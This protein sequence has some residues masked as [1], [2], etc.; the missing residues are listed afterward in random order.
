MDKKQVD[1]LLYEMS[2]LYDNASSEMVDTLQKVRKE[3]KA[4]KENGM[5]GDMPHQDL[6]AEWGILKDGLV[7]V[8]TDL[9]GTQVEEIASL[10]EI[11]PALRAA[12][13]DALALLH[14]RRFHSARNAFKALTEKLDPNSPLAAEV[15]EKQEEAGRKLAA[16]V[17]PLI[18]KAQKYDRNKPGDLEQRRS[19]WEA[20]TEIDP[21]NQTARQALES[22]QQEGSRLRIQK[23]QEELLQAMQRAFDARNLPDANTQLGALEALAEANTFIDLQAELDD[24]VKTASEQRAKLREILGAASTLSVQGNTREGYKQ[25]REFL[26]AGV[27]VMVD[28]AGFLGPANAE[29]KTLELVKVTQSRF[30]ASLIDLTQQRRVLAEEQQRE[31]PALAKKTLEN[32][33]DL[34]DDD[35]LTDEDRQELEDTRQ[36]IE[37]ELTQVEERIRHYEQA[38]TLVLKANEAGVSFEEKL[39]LYREAKEAY[40]EYRNLDNYIEDTQD[41]LAAQ[42]AGRIKDKLTSIRLDLG[43][44]EF[45]KALDGVKVVRLQ[46]YEEVPQ[47]KPGSELQRVLDELQQLE[48]EIITADGQYHAMMKL[49]LEVDDLLEQYGEKQDAN[50]LAEVRQRLDSLPGSQAQHSQVR[51]R[52]LRLTNTQGDQENWRQGMEAYRIREWADAQT[53]LR[54]VADSPKAANRVEAERL[55]RRAQAALYVAEARQAELERN[56]RRAIDHYKEAYR[57]F[58]ENGS[59]DQT[60]LLHDDCRDKLDS[61]KPLE[62]N[63]QQ[64]RHVIAQAESLVREGLQSVQVRRSLLE[65]VEPVTQFKRAVEKLLEVRQQ[66]TTLTAELERTLREAREAW[67]KT[68]LEGMTQATRS[69]DVHILQRA[70]QRG[71]EL[72]AQNLLYEDNDKKL[73][74][75]L[76]EQLLDT[77]YANLQVEKVPDPARVE[78]NRRKR[79]EIANPKTDE[80]YAQFQI[81]MEQRVLLQL[82]EE[83]SKSNEAALQHLK[84]EMRRPELYQSERLFREFMH[85]CWET[86]NWQEARK[87]GEG[88]K[89]R[90][91]VVQAEQKSIVWVGLT[92]AAMLLAQ[93]SLP[94]FRAELNGLSSIGQKFPQMTFLIEDEEQWL[95]EWRLE[96]LLRE[97][98]VAGGSQDEQQLIKAA[99]LFAEAHELREEDV[100]VQT[101]LINLGQKLNSSLE[102]YAGQAKNLNIRK[103]LAESIRRA[104][105]LAF[106]LQSIQKVQGVLNLKPETV[107]AL[108][109]G[110]EHIQNK[111][112]PWKKTQ[113]Q[114]DRLEK[115]KTDYL[116]Y[117]EPL[118]PDGSG[119]WRVRD[120]V[121]QMTPLTQIA[122]GDRELIQLINTRR[123]QLTELD[124]KAE[125][126]NGQAHALAQAIQSEAFDEV[127]GAAN[128]LEI[129]WHRYQPDG[130]SGLDILIRHRYP[131]TEK[132]LRQLREHKEEA[133]TQKANLE[134]WQNWAERV[135]KTYAE[136]KAVGSR[137]DKDL[138]DLR[139]DAPLDEIKRSCDQVL[140]KTAEFEAALG[141]APHTNPMSQK[142]AQARD[143]VAETWRGEV[144]DNPKS[145]QN[146]ASELLTQI[147][148]DLANFA[149]PLKQLRSA[150]NLLD[151]QIQQHEDSKSKRFGKTRP[152]PTAQLR[153]ATERLKT[154]QEIDPSHDEV[155]VFNKRLRQIRER[156]GV[157]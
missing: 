44:D 15:T 68:Y 67:R 106:I 2:E 102:I 66:D 53:F 145:F 152:F 17:S 146:H 130:F 12:F 47:P 18:D 83:Q 54:Q 95:I 74:Q 89:Y 8:E 31:T 107:E 70:V 88:L 100:R 51:Q 142:A 115:A 5:A 108:E 129:L 7:I 32:T 62:E 124:T 121:D 34:L 80:L 41:A 149:Q 82:S 118:R 26:T 134:E 79:W 90:A 109:D 40:P 21:D 16:Q 113:A 148:K 147:E 157:S 43:R 112:T 19:L 122:Q 50:L 30:I 4:W 120:L 153:N 14:N 111:L 69:R 84:G 46:V 104:E 64:V 128:R 10:E 33:L 99:Q 65:R 61:L 39:R 13:D 3:I 78:E 52:R 150:M 143:R 103:S 133:R 58:D 91:H 38:R 117:P 45:E 144:L 141:Q 76:Q 59:D 131:Y 6:L 97:A 94:S 92:Q 23:E 93:G 63:D 37:S 139:Q 96:K 28:A 138:A 127:L 42:L 49:L 57:L 110:R 11:D 119:G 35:L 132:E 72:Q 140:E 48:Q 114:F 36:N 81:A 87:Q 137:I 125:E 154:C 60:N 116:T 77:E 73:L 75:Q 20:V 9:A 155:V 126:L 101:G 24:A 85:L 105:D 1:T 55:G 123:E 135:T 86:A 156:Y 56:W 136:V 27:G 29:V 22:L 71:E 25:A 151:S 98:Q